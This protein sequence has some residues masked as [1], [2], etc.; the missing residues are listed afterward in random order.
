MREAVK[1]RGCVGTN[2]KQSIQ[3]DI[4]PSAPIPC[5]YVSCMARN[6]NGAADDFE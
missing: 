4:P 2:A 6:R 5:S 3:G 1:G